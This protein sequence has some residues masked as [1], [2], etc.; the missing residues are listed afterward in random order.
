MNKK[1][2]EAIMNQVEI[3]QPN[4]FSVIVDLGLG[5]YELIVNNISNFKSKFEYYL[6][7]YDENMYHLHAP[8]RIVDI[9]AADDIKI[10]GEAYDNYLKEIFQ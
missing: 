5:E 1:Q 9:V 10:I 3:Y 4:Y 6:K 7:A 2:F 8:I